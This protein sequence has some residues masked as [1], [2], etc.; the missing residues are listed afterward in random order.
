VSEKT[1]QAITSRL[2]TSPESINSIIKVLKKVKKERMNIAH[3]TREE[4]NS[5]VG[6]NNTEFMAELLKYFNDQDEG[7]LLI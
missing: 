4:K 3:L 5:L 6:K 2:N 7:R 1:W